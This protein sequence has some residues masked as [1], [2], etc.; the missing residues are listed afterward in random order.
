MPVIGVL[1]MAATS[2]SRAAP[3]PPKPGKDRRPRAHTELACRRDRSGSRSGRRHRASLSPARPSRSWSPRPEQKAHRRSAPPARR[4]WRPPP[5]P[6]PVGASAATFSLTSANAGTGSRIRARANRRDHMATPRQARI[7]AGSRRRLASEAIAV[8]AEGRVKR[9]GRFTTN[10]FFGDDLLVRFAW[11]VTTFS[12][13]TTPF[14]PA[15]LCSGY[16]SSLPHCHA[17]RK[18]VRGSGGA[19]EATGGAGT[20]GKYGPEPYGDPALR[21]R[22]LNF[23]CEKCLGTFATPIGAEIG[24][25]EGIRTPDTRFRKRDFTVLAQFAAV[26]AR[27]KGFATVRETG[28]GVVHEPTRTGVN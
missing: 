14:R 9:A 5:T 18:I 7:G 4:P 3:A 6:G 8:I 28:L 20:G 13:P 23:A 27:S 25:P 11:A 17:R 16:I 22:Q 15:S 12:D 10:G 19:C 1:P 26:H 24:V 2:W 21:V